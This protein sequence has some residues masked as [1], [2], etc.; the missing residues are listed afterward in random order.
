MNRVKLILVFFAFLGLSYQSFNK[1]VIG[2]FMQTSS[3]PN[4]PADQFTWVDACDVQHWQSEGAQIVPI[5]SSYSYEEIDYLLERVNGVHFPGGGADLWLNV[6]NK[7]GF[8]DMTLKAQHILNRTLE[9]NSQGR[10][11]PLQGTCLGLELITLAY[12]NYSQVLSDYNDDNICR[13]V[14]FLSYGKMYQNMSSFLKSFISNG[15]ALYVYHHWGL[16]PKNFDKFMSKEFILTTQM[17]DFDDNIYVGSYEHKQYPIYAIQFHPE[18]ERFNLLDGVNATHS[19]LQIETSKYFA[20]FFVNQVRLNNHTFEDQELLER[21]AIYNFSPV[22]I[23]GSFSQQE[24]F[25]NNNDTQH[26]ISLNK[27]S[28]Y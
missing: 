26:R 12:S 22:H 17:R 23:N 4:F 19:P 20:N 3:D 21:I 10:F 24:Y 18:I 27:T 16:S 2:L 5:Y 6:A 8:T 28:Q 1:P 9:W 13:P 25:F 14:E 11:F 7:T 15:Q